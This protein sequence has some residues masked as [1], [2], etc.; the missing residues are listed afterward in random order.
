MNMFDASP[1]HSP[2]SGIDEY[3]VH[4]YPTPTRVMWTSDLQA[5]ERMLF[6]CQDSVGDL[7]V[8]CGIAFYP[9]LGTADAFAIV[10]CRGKHTT[11]RAHRFLGDNRMDRRIGPLNFEVVQPF[12]EWR[13]TLADNEFDVT[14]D[15]RWFDTK[16]AIFRNLLAG[17]ITNGRISNGTA[18]YD[19]FGTQEGTVT[20]RGESFSV[21][22]GQYRGMRDHH[23]GTRDGVGGPALYRGPQWPFSGQWVEFNDWGAWGEHIL[24]NIGDPRPGSEALRRRDH[25]LRFEPETKLLV[26]G[27]IDMYFQSGE[28]KTMTFERMGDQIAFLRCA[29][30]GG[31]NGGTPDGDIWHGM[32]VGDGVVTGETYDV[33]D[34]AV[35]SHLCGLDEYHARCECDGEVTYGLLEC[36]DTLCY[37]VAAA[38]KMDSAD[39]GPMRFEIIE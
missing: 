3:F 23:W 37:E 20:V 4:N 26:S 35:R 21:T 7:L 15:I 10:N 33:S 6:T 16:R 18:G 24:Y 17:A 30:Y 25:R 36:Y 39:F 29:M 12:R 19:V 28:V 27:E 13:L 9:N 32:E 22:R 14:F 11:V 8:M 34:P 38:G 31:P 5:Y 2:M 1:E